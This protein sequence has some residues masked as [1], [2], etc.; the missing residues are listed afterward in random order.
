MLSLGLIGSLVCSPKRCCAF[1]RVISFSQSS[2][3]W[4]LASKDSSRFQNSSSSHG[5][6]NSFVSLGPSTNDGKTK[7]H[8]THLGLSVNSW[9]LAHT[10]DPHLHSIVLLASKHTTHSIYTMFKKILRVRNKPSF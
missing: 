6:N 3:T 1:S 7:E 2:K 5:F 8:C 4:V 9:H 10:P